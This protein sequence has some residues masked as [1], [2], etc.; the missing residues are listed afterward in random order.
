MS[1]NRLFWI[2]PQVFWSTKSLTVVNLASTELEYLT[3]EHLKPID[4]LLTSL[5]LTDMAKLRMD[6]ATTLVKC[7]QLRTLDLSGS[8]NIDKQLPFLEKLTELR[9]NGIKLTQVDILNF[10][11][12]LKR[13]S[14]DDNSLGDL[15]LR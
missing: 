5:N 2:S 9:L 15:D 12:N 1:Q 13:L 10:S 4:D 11:P 8:L 7:Q 3:F 6:P 14:L